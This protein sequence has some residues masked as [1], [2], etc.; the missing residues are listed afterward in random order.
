VRRPAAWRYV[1]VVVLFALGLMAKPMLVTLP[2]TLLLLD[3]WPLG[4]AETPWARRVVEKVPLFAMSVASSIMT[5]IAQRG[6]IASLDLVPLADR[7]ANAVLSYG[8]YL[9]LLAWP[10]NLAILY[11][12][13]VPLPAAP[14]VLAGFVIAALTALA[15]RV[16]KTMPYVLVGWLWFLG[17]LVPVIGV[18]QVG[19]QALADR[20]AYIPSIGVFI[21][22][23]WGGRAL[24]S[25]LRLS[26]VVLRTIGVALVAGLAVVAHAQIATWATNETLWRQAVAA[27][28]RNPRAHI[29]LGVV[30]GK[31]GR[32][33]E[34]AAE[35]ELALTFPLS[36][37][38]GR[39]VFPNL[40]QAL[41]DQG[42]LAEAIPRLEKA[43]ELSPERADICHRLALAYFGV[44]RKDD[45]IAAWRE[46]VRLN[47]RFEEA[48]FTMG[49]VL[50]A[51]GRRDEALKALTEV[52]RINPTR[53]D[54]QE[55]LAALRK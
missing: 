38:E 8:R 21:A 30:Y 15:W 37:A 35:L 4:R 11:P 3:I 5:T 55:A 2:F 16:R 41:M 12:L 50:A 14:V 31:A 32:P 43:R 9:Q 28:S 52:L 39:D 23:A 48:Y 7:I 53:K 18:M 10:S 46:A 49:I 27:T 51:N 40:G 45:A 25:R 26:P 1:L 44:N 22:L 29:E 19:V 33:A 20:Y 36:E 47:P 6:A 42:K 24:A 17:T 13:V 54:A 34:A